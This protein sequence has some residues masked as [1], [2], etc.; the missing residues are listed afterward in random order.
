[1]TPLHILLLDD[2]AFQ[3]KLL[4]RQL[5]NIWEARLDLC[6]SGPAALACLADQT[7]AVELLFLD[8]N[9]PDM[10]GI[11]FIRHLVD[12]QYA[13]ALVLVSGEDERILETAA[14]LARAQHMNV[15]GHLT[16]PVQPEALR[17]LLERWRDEPPALAGKTRK[18]YDPAE[19]R[20]AIDGGELV[21]FYQPK[22]D[23]LSG[24]LAGVETLVRWQHPADG[25]V[26]PDQFIGIAEQHGLIDDLT[27]VVLAG[28][29]AQARRWRDAGLSLRVAVNISMDN[30]ARLDF[31]DFVLAEI[32][33]H[34][35]A[36][37]DIILELTESRLM[38]NSSIPLDILTRLRLKKISLSIDDFGTGHSS[39]AQLRDIPFDEL[40]IDYSFVHGAHH[41]AT[42]RAIFSASL[43]MARQLRMKSVAEGVEDRA[44]WDF[45]RAQ[46][47]DL[48]QGYFIARPMAAEDLPA[49][50]AGWEVRCKELLSP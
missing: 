42:R 13:G 6:T 39:L 31:P 40:K 34:G 12:H 9:M 15:I 35:L 8:L 41:D 29:L 49:W 4:A 2:D 14:R 21:N 23:V 28:A 24:A 16:K 43:G 17:V 11:E 20:R 48:A 50:L 3:L 47:C 32:V 37:N 22:V 5:A 18:V 33:R 44:D 7:G 46:D 10:D 1:M 38:K 30:L 25:L 19:L 45:L 36:P 26:F 27:R